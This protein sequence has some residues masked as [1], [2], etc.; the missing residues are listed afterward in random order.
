M[1]ILIIE[2]EPQTAN[3]LKDLII[4]QNPS[5]HVSA[6]L[7]SIEDSVKYLSLAKNHPDIIFMDIQLADGLSFDIFPRV[8]ISCPVVFCT[9]YDH[10]A[11]R[12]FKSN[13]VEYLLK[14]V[15]EADIRAAFTKLESLKNAFQAGGEIINTLKNMLLERKKY[16]N[17]FLLRNRE[18]LIPVETS[19]IALFVLEKEI[20]NAWCFDNQKY[21][22]FSPLDEFEKDV[23]P[24]Q[25][26]RISRQALI[27][28]KAIK[29][30]EPYFNRKLTVNTQFKLDERLVVS[31]LK[32]ADFLQWIESH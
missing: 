2:D 28:R 11:L 21:T 20:L 5:F 27:N 26:Y 18:S 8:Q 15:K 32:V 3:V 19:N 23:D 31:R 30:I 12:A 14:P 1:N 17:A 25:F 22:L 29:K 10:Y 6:I 7:E 24:S 13:G 4:R 16:K 9:A